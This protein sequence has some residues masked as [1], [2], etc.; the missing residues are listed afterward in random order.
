[1][2]NRKISLIYKSL[3]SKMTLSYDKIKKHL[4]I[5]K[6]I[7]SKPNLK[8]YKVF[9]SINTNNDP[10][11]ITE[12]DYYNKVE[13]ILNN[14]AFSE[15]YCDKNFYHNY[16]DNSI[17]PRV[18]LRNI[19]GTYYDGTFHLIQPIND[20]SIWI[21]DKINKIIAKN[22][23]DSGG[24]EGVAL[25]VRTGKDWTD[26]KG[27]IITK[28]YLE[29]VFENNFLLQEYIEQHPFIASLIAPRSTR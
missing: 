11:Y 25:F 14:R 16:L 13:L 10:E 9:A 29:K 6:G 27:T 18:F 4:D 15:A 20:L 19:Q 1:M 12:T 3:P 26:A 17:L 23:I 24:G 21:P 8:W 22:S 5:W 28:S 2:M 7:G